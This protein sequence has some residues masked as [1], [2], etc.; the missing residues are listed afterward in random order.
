MHSKTFSHTKSNIFKE[1][2]IKADQ[3]DS[4]FFLRLIASIPQ[5]LA[6]LTEE[7]EFVFVNQ[8]FTSVFGYTFKELNTFSDWVWSYCKKEEYCNAMLELWNDDIDKLFSGSE[9]EI[10]REFKLV[11]K[12]GK[13]K[14]VELIYNYLNGFLI[15]VFNEI[16]EKRKAEDEIK[17]KNE[18]LIEAHR[19]ARIGSWKYYLNSEEFVWSDELFHI[20][21]YK[22]DEENP[23]I[24]LKKHLQIDKI[25]N[26]YDLFD[27][28]FIKKTGRG[29][30]DEYQIK[31]KHNKIKY[32]IIQGKP[33]CDKYGGHI[34]VKGIF[35]DITEKKLQEIELQELNNTKERLFSIIAHDLKNP[36]GIMAGLT[37][38][39]LEAIEN[40]DLERMQKYGRLLKLSA[41][42]GYELLVNLLDWAGAQNNKIRFL[43][44]HVKLSE[45]LDE[46]FKLLAGVIDE[47]KIIIL[48]LIDSDLI[49]CADINMLKAIFRNLISNAIKYSYR[50]GEVKI[51]VSRNKNSDFS[52]SITD[53]G[54]GIKDERKKL[55]F[56]PKAQYTTHGTEK[57]S[58]TGLGL[59]VC[60]DF[61][62]RHGGSIW[63]ESTNGNG[64][65]FSFTLPGMQKET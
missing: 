34:G 57:E 40:G 43:P 21:G 30:V 63:F 60:R 23:K 31:D 2:E 26:V 41:N 20:F 44:E 17:Q 27:D 37:D 3:T 11:S 9:K 1:L 58:G 49:V 33:F 24:I 50:G 62:E 10:K 56:D 25:Y 22:P 45:V 38:V 13:E 42:K 14:L 59:L 15:I 29:Y 19:L 6:I 28:I 8:K 12:I 54:I 16:T 5:A 61:V 53:N 55:I 65:I 46:I 35:Q 4:K 51:T 52:F 48:N 36:I 47:K 32:I 18:Q 64:S 7:G 39:L